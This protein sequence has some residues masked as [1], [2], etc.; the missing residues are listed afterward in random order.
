MNRAIL[1]LCLTAALAGPSAAQYPSGYPAAPYSPY[2]QQPQVQP[3]VFNRNT[4]PLSPY[5]NLFNGINNPNPALNYYYNVRPGTVGGTGQRFGT[6]APFTSPG[7]PRMPFFPQL[8]NAPD[9]ANV[10]R[11]VG[12]GDVLPPAGHPVYFNNTFGFFPGSGRGFSPGL[13]GIGNS[14]PPARR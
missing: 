9:P 10:L 6:G 4:Q 5:L 2:Y 11:E 3:N 1:T 12:V 7:A 14:R 8:A 13:S